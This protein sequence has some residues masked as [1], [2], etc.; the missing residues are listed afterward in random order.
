[1]TTDYDLDPPPALVVL[2]G[3]ARH[4]TA[5]REYEQ[6]LTC[7]GYIVLSLP[8]VGP[9]SGSPLLHQWLCGL[10]RAQLDLAAQFLGRGSYAL[11]VNPDR[12]LGE[13]TAQM[14]AYAE[15]L[16]LPVRYA[17]DGGCYE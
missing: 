2:L 1:M 7:S 13:S 5:F 15:S 10:R 6:A 14:V 12:E 16:G 4:E 11:V 17:A 3:S 9:R 8:A